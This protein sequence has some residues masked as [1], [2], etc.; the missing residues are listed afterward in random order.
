VTSSSVRVLRNRLAL[1][2][3][4]LLTLG[5]GQAFAQQHYRLDPAASVVGFSLGDAMHDVKGTF[6]LS[7]GDIAFDSK[8]GAMS[9]SIVVD[10]SSG[11][12]DS[13]ARDKKMTGDQLKA[14]AFPSVTF[15]PVKFTGT[16]NDSGDSTIQVEGAFTLIGQ[17]HTITVPMTV[18]VESGHCTATG[19]FIVPYVSWG[20]KDPSVMFLKVAKEVK[21]DLKLSGALAR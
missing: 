8:S 7:S 6:H 4:A 13:K 12:S 14:S 3:A 15:A 11:Q 18:H 1:L 19:S 10:A 21:I 17:P 20:V 5:S 2:A 16:L 9:G